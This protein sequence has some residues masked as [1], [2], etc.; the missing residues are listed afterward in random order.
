MG[1]WPPPIQFLADQIM[2][3]TLLHDHPPPGFSYL[4]T[5]LHLYQNCLSSL[6]IKLLTNMMFTP[7][8]DASFDSQKTNCSLKFSRTWSKFDKNKLTYYW[9]IKQVEFNVRNRF[10]Y[11]FSLH[12]IKLENMMMFAV[13]LKKWTLMIHGRRQPIVREYLFYVNGTKLTKKFY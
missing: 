5:A 6:M 10:K 12:S 9:R 8:L 1:T 7:R 13:Q 3:T 4:P 2:R 11:L